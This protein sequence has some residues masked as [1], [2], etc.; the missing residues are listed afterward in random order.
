MDETL[1]ILTIAGT[2]F[3]LGT[4]SALVWKRMQLGST[5]RIAADIV[6]T[7]EKEVLSLRQQGELS[8]KQQ[9]F[10]KERELETFVHA[11]RQKLQREEERLKGREDK[12]ELRQNSLE[13]KIAELEKRESSLQVSRQ[14]LEESLADVAAD[15]QQ[16]VTQLE[17]LSGV[18]SSEAKEQL[19]ARIAADLTTTTDALIRRKQR[20]AEESAER[21]AATTI[22]TAI[23]RLCVPCVTEAT[24]T[25]VTLPNDE[26]KGRIIGREGRN[27]RMLERELGVNILVD[28]TPGAVVLSGFDPVRKQI[29]KLVITELLKDGRIHPTRILEVIE[30]KKVELD[31]QIIGLGEDAAIRA[32]ALNLHPAFMTLLGQ[33]KFR[34]SYGQNVLD[35]SLEVSALMGMM[36]AELGLN[37]NLAKRIGLLHDVGK[38]VSH[39]IPGPHALVGFDLALKYGESKE[40][41]NGIGC[42][43]QEMEPDT[44]EASLC[45][46]A[47]AISASRPGARSGA[48]EEYVKRLK[49]LEEITYD[50]PGVERAYAM[51]AGR[52]IYISVLP[53]IVDDAGV[54]NLARDIS[55]RIEERMNYAGRVKVTVVR[56][57]RVVEYA[58]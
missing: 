5:E 3:L 10:D 8:L 36:A 53:E 27:I 56:E 30:Q 43:H 7:A 15:R 47:D 38:A 18:T 19:L 12:L 48:L 14:A 20:E 16:L 21:I 57:K 22:A 33:L 35:H 37:V 6:A 42:H 25:T 40:V 54:A 26:M 51:Q 34:Y 13:K 11:E 28:D 41:A 39:E 31:K 58:G 32:G 44:V 29:A 50:F 24:I 4:I 46:A 52:E 55:K 17:S 23:N 2:T 45:S 9:Q 1:Q 49:D